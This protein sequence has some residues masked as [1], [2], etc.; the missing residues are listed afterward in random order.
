MIGVCD[1]AA[2][3]HTAHNA[4]E[5]RNMEAM[6]LLKPVYPDDVLERH[7]QYEQVINRT[8]RAKSL[9]ICV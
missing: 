8:I 6:E 1:K 9:M 5:I 2:S 4:T 3:E 7:N